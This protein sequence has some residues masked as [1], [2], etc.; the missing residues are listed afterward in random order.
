MQLMGN[1]MESSDKV[2]DVTATK[3]QPTALQRT[4]QAIDHGIAAGTARV[5]TAVSTKPWTTIGVSLFVAALCTLGFMNLRTEDQ[6]DKLFVPDNSRA[7]G[8][9]RWVESRF[10]NDETVSTMILNHKDGWNLLDKAALLEAFDVYDR[11]MAISTDG[12]TR[13]YDS[14]SCAVNNVNPALPCQKSGI[15]AFWGWDRA[16]LEADDDII[17][18]INRQDAPDCC[19]AASR[20]VVLE[21]DAAKLKRD[22]QGNVIEV[23]ALQLNFYLRAKTKKGG[24]DSKNR[25]LEKKFDE[26]RDKGSYDYMQ[27]PLKPLTSYAQSENV[28]RGFDY[29][30]T[31]INGAS[32]LIFA[33]A[34]W[35]MHQR[36]DPYASRGWL[37]VAAAGVVLVA[38][39]AGFGLA[40]AFGTV[41]SATASI[42][43]FLI[44]GIGLDDAFVI[45]GAELVHRAD[46]SQ[47][48]QKV[49]D[50]GDVQQIASKRVIRAMAAAGPSIFVTSITDA[51]AFYAGSITT[52]PAIRAFCLFCGT[53][54]LTDYLLQTTLFVAILTLDMRLK[55]K[56]GARE[57][58]GDDA[59][60][61]KKACVK[62]AMS[63]P[64][65]NGK[66]PT[67]FFGGKYAMV[68]LSVPGMV[69][70]LASTA[71]LVCMAA[72]GAARVEADFK[73]EWFFVDQD[74]FGNDL[75][76]AWFKEEFEFREKFFRAGNQYPVGVYTS[77]ADYF[78]EGAT[79]KQFYGD[80]AE[81]AY[82]VTSS[83]E[84]NWYDQ[85]QLW[86]AGDPPSTSEEYTTSVA[87]WLQSE[88]AGYQD[89]VIMDGNNAII[90]TKTDVRW[91]F[92]RKDISMPMLLNRMLRS[93]TF[94]RK[95]AS[96][97]KPHFYSFAFVFAEGIRVVLRESVISLLI[98]CLVV[99]IVLVLL[100]GDLWAA[101]LVAS[102][103]FMVCLITYG[104]IYWYGD[105]L[106]NV[107]AFFVIIAVGLATDASAHY[108]VA[109]LES[110]KGTSKER[111]VEALDL[112]G[113]PVFL[114]GTSTILGICLTGFCVT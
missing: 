37:G 97:V 96:A 8:D 83:V 10:P 111:A 44:L 65:I 62:N 50:G 40:V 70:V 12:G 33:Y 88:G 27:K 92:N 20:T 4:A 85:H 36:K 74:A 107:S 75:P 104:S 89:Y 93:R 35:A 94:G 57:L 100:L 34:F 51:V 53:C 73:Y 99:A 81:Q 79:T 39:A 5:A 84:G 110:S 52:I 80:Y 14:R 13:G 103:V 46:F 22:D 109:F 1:T 60:W 68:L 101:F 98:A 105:A 19:S 11:V 49:L 87:A 69:F 28:G 112:L 63:D 6:P 9:R 55:L 95:Q 102:S 76:Y 3:R 64:L 26:L 42:A 72:V 15:L 48:A 17:E 67:S 108:C 7:F 47:D 32:V 91:Q 58:S 54:V 82:V 71:G 56:R 25:E 77:T 43:I 38:V 106:N 90:A 30:Q 78:V 2:D 59:E 21:M 113:P 31:F 29:D 45:V 86:A 114:G 18:T 41:F 23:G 66:R 24:R 16:T 61:C